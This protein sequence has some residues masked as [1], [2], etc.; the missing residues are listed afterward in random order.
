M[1]E[2]RHRNASS[3]HDFTVFNQQG[4]CVFSVAHAYRDEGTAD[5]L[6]VAYGIWF[7]LKQL[8]MKTRPAQ[9][10]NNV[11]AYLT[12]TTNVYKVHILESPTGLLFLLRTEPAVPDMFDKLVK[13]SKEFVR[14][15]DENP[16][17][18]LGKALGNMKGNFL[19]SLMRRLSSSESV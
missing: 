10:R 13:C 1:T 8:V 14:F 18:G 19:D 7:S 4:A 17:P 5:A 3:V 16:V 6:K 11:A 9:E 15:V 12:F 2:N